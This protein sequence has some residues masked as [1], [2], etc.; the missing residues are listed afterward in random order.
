MA[1]MTCNN[2][3]RHFATKYREDRLSLLEHLS[4]CSFERIFTARR[5]ISNQC[6]FTVY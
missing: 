5:S 6:M 2:A 4:L 3:R 1:L